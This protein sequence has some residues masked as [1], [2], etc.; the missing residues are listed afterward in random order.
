MTGREKFFGDGVSAAERSV[1]S[2]LEGA[3]G[4]MTE[5]VLDWS[6]M[7]TGSANLDGLERMAGI[8]KTSFSAL[9]A[10]P[11]LLDPVPV[12]TIDGAGEVRTIRRGRNL[13]LSVRTQ[14]PV[15]V[16]LTGHMDT[17]FPKD[18]AFQ[19]ATWREPGVLN[20]PGVADMKGGL[21]VMLEA[22]KALE[23]SPWAERL[24]YQVVINSDE[25]VSSIGSV[26][27]LQDAASRAH[28]GL[29][30]EPATTPE[31]V[32]AGARKGLAAFTLVARGVS[33]HAGRDHASGRNAVVAAADFAVRAAALSG[34]RE[35]LTINVGRIEGGGPTNVVPDLALCRLEAR[36]ATHEDRHWVEA[37]LARLAAAVGADHRLTLELNGRFTRPPKPLDASTQALFEAVAACG[38]QLGQPISWKP[39][40]GC[41][42]GNNLAEAGL[43]VVDTLGVRGGLIHSRDEFL[44]TESLVERAQLSALLLMRLAAGTIPCPPRI[45]AAA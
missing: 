5:T 15:Q 9:G 10:E 20:G 32:L 42:D 38:A 4:R 43:P 34:A 35:G 39:T 44:I 7:N 21:Q 30:Y 45:G 27:L 14:A 13:H 3:Q 12:E 6:A 23:A 26:A 36:V 16:L 41:C 28:V 17:V 1:L 8:L 24:G 2:A 29:V 37:E 11:A 19:A 31:G 18:D 40:G 33:A 22:L 25:E